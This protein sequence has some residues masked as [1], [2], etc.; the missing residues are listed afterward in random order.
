MAINNSGQ[1]AG[2]FIL[3][4]SFYNAFL[5]SNGSMQDLGTLGG[6][7]SQ[8][9]GINNSGQVVGQ[10]ING[11]RTSHA[12]LYTG[13]S[14]QD[15]GTL[16]YSTDTSIAYGINN[17]GVIV[18]ADPTISHAFV[19]ANGT[20]TDLNTLI[21]PVNSGWTLQDACAIN[22][23]GQIAGYGVNPAGQVHAFVL[24][25]ISSQW[26]DTITASTSRQSFTTANQ[27]ESEGLIVITH[28]WIPPEDDPTADTAWVDS[29]SNSITA[30]LNA[31][32]LTGWQVLGWKWLQGAQVLLPYGPQ[33]ALENSVQQGVNLGQYILANGYT[34]VHLI[35]HSA[36]AGLIQSA[37]D[38]IKNPVS[39]KPSIVVHETFLAPFV[40]FDF[41]G[42]QTYG[43]GAD[44]ADNYSCKAVGTSPEILPFTYNILEHA[45]NVDVTQID[46]IDRVQMSYFVSGDGTPCYTTESTHSWPISFYSNTITGSVTSDYDGFGFPL[47]EEGAP[48]QWAYALA[49]YTPGNPAPGKIL[50]TS[51]PTG[52]TFDY[53]ATGYPSTIT[54]FINSPYVQS[55]TGTIQRYLNGSVKHMSGS[56]A[57]LAT[58]VTVTN[59]VNIVSFDAEFQSGTGSQG[60]LSI[61]WDTNTI[62]SLDERFVE[63]GFQHYVLKFPS[64]TNFSSHILGFRLD[65]FTNIQSVVVLTNVSTSYSGVSQGFSLSI[66][67]NASNGSM[68]YQLSGQSG[69]EY[70]IQASSDLL[71]WT[72]IALLGNTNGTVNFYDTNAVN[73]PVCRFYRA[74]A[75]Y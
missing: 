39:G 55:T 24:N 14:M 69:Y 41:S 36:G 56:P 6:N 43:Y 60:L 11:S 33:T 49:N 59:S 71:N 45:Y 13:G 25:P 62:G 22:D 64:V 1:I 38:T 63:P 27:S 72:N 15:L 37:T 8:A 52:C 57:W 5:Y 4:N 68:V 75:P 26:Q 40:G 51:D 74:V 42:Q 70:T 54:D 17:N 10:S 20:M 35:A 32:S 7:Q 67:T 65:P 16:K 46:V 3:T 30:Y 21:A 34:H 12:F 48:G 50:G 47:S 53:P 66:T 44:W 73:Y 2:Y 61:Y 58:F 29:M 18:G 9:W 28:G 23:S 31:N 19:Y